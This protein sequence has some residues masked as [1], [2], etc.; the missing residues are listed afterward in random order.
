MD[1][2]RFHV[3]GLVTDEA[4]REVSG[5]EVTVFLQR[6]RD[7][8]PLAR[9]RADEDGRY[10]LSYEPPEHV[11]GRVMLVV[12]ATG[13]GLQGDIESPI[14]EAAPDLEVNLTRTPREMSEFSV[15]EREVLPLLDGLSLD[16]VVESAEHQDIS[17]LAVD[18]NRGTEAITRLVLAARL[19]S[20]YVIPAVVFYAF[21]ALRV[22]SAI[23]SPL[24]P[25]T[26]NWELI[27]G[28]VKRIASLIFVLTPDVQKQTLQRASDGGT[29]PAT[30]PGHID[31]FVAQLQARRVADALDGPFQV[32]KATLGELLTVAKLP[33]QKQQAFATALTNN[34]ESMRNFWRHLS[35]PGSGFTPAEASSIQRSLEVGSFTKNH[36][37]LVTALVDRFASGQYTSMADL[38]RLPL[39][40]WNDLVAQV[41]P[42]ANV[43]AAG[44]L[45]AAQVYAKVIYTRVTRAFPTV[46]LSTRLSDS[47]V[48]P[49]N[50][51]DSL[52][53]FFTNNPKLE[54]VKANVTTYVEQ[55]GEEAFSGIAVE[56]RPAVIE[57]AKQLQRVLRVTPNVD[58]AEALLRSGI[59]SA[60][61]I[62]TLGRQQFFAK[63]VEL[64]LTKREANRVYNMGAQ[65]YADTVSL[66]TQ[67]NRSL[68]GD[69]PRAV[70]STSDLDE[71]TAQAVKR[72]QSLATLFGSQDYC[73]TDN[74]TSILSA[75]AYLC[76]LL[77]WLRNHPLSGPYANALLALRARRPD[78]EHLLLN[79]PNTE[80]PLPYIDLVNELLEDAVA[81]PAMPV[82]RQTTLTPP[83]LRAAPEYVN[84]DAYIA[85][86]AANYPHTLPYDKAMDELRTYLGQS[87][88]E[89]W[90]LRRQLLPLHSPTLPQRAGVAAARFGIDAH[91]TDLICTPNDVTAAVAWNTANPGVDLVGVPAFLQAA[92]I[93]YE[94][95]LE[96]L[97]VVWIRAGGAPLT[98]Q[99]VDDTCDL[100]LQSLAPAPLDAGD[101]D[102][103]HR[104][105]RMWRH[106]NWTMWE[107]DLL[108]SA[109]AVGAGVLDENAL[110]QLAAFN[111]LQHA[112]RLGVDELL[113]LFGNIDLLSHRDPS[114]DLTTSL[115]ARLFLDPSVPADP[116]LA[117]LSIGA[118][119]ADPV[120]SHHV[121]SVR[122]ALQV[123]ADDATTLMTLTDGTLTLA[124]L[125]KMCR[126]AALATVVQLTIDD[127]LRVI[128]VAGLGDTDAALTAIVH[129]AGTTLDFIQNVRDVKQSGFSIDEVMYVLTKQPT[130]VG[131]TTD[132]ITAAV[133]PAVRTAMQAA[134]DE[135][136]TSADPALTVLQRELAQLPQFADSATLA[137]MISIVDDTYS[138]ALAARN[139]FI[140]ANLVQFMD[141]ATAQ[142]DL[143]PLPGGLTHA[144]RQAAVTQRAQQ[145]LNPLAVYLT[146]TRVTAALAAATQLQPAVV[147][148]LMRQVD[149]PGTTTTML[150]TLTDPAIIHKTGGVYTPITSANFPN[151]FAAIQL[152][153]KIGT[154]VRRLH[155]VPTDLGWLLTNAATYGGPDLRQLPVLPAT[156]ELSYPAL[157]ATS[158][159]VKLDRSFS[160]APSGAAY[161]DLYSVIAAVSSGG[162]ASAGATQTALGVI[163]GWDATDIGLLATTLGV[164]FPSDYTNPKTYDALRRLDAMMAASGGNATQL[165]SWGV[166][167]PSPTAAADSV[168]S[169]LKSRY[170][171]AD[172][173]QL[174]P[175]LMDPLRERRSAALQA[176][177]LAKRDGGGALLFS[178][179][180]ALFEHFLIDVEMSSCQVTTRVIQAYA[181]VQLFVERAL[182]ALEE[183]NVVVDP[184][185][186]DTW[187]QWQ[188]MKRYRVW[189]AAREVFLYPENWLVESQRP[190]RTEL[191][192]KLEQEVHQNENTADYLETVAL[193]YIDRL[194][195][196]AHLTVTGTC[197][198]PHTGAVHVVARTVADP[199]KFYHR[200]FADRTWSG[201]QQIPVDIK[202]HQAVP[203]VFRRRLCIFWAEVKV[204]G[205]PRQDVP[206]A[207]ASTNAPPDPA[208]YVS[209]GLNF[210]VFRNGAW[211]PQ[212]RSRGRLFDLP[213]LN[214]QTVSNSTAIEALYTLKVQTPAPAPG[215]GAS[216]SIDVFRLG[217]YDVDEFSFFVFDVFFP[218][219]DRPNAAVHIGRATF[220]G[221]F[222]DLEQRNLDIVIG[223][224]K[225][226][227]LEHA[228]TAYGPDALPLLELPSAQ[229][230]PNLAPEPGPLIPQGG[231][232]TTAPPH[233]SGT[234]PLVFTSASSLQQGNGPLLNTGQVPFRVIGDDSDIEFDPGS[235]F[236]YQDNRR[237]YFVES[238]K[239]YQWGSAWLPNPPSYASTAPYEQRYAFH[240]FY[241][242]Y[243]RLMW[244]QLSGGGFPALY[245]R[246]FQL[247]PDTVDPSGADRFSFRNTYNPVTPRVSWGE[248]NEIIAFEPDA[249]YSVYNWELFFHTPLY[250]AERLSQN[251]RFEDALAWFHYLFDPTRSGTEPVPQRFWITKPLNTLTTTA[252]LQERINN[253][254][255]AV[256]H[257]DANAVAQVARWRRD[258]FNPFLLADQRPVAYM[259]RVVMSYLDNLIAW[260]DNLFSSD[261]REALNEATLLYVIAAEI[262]GPRPVAVTP[263]QHLDA[264][265]HDL[266]PKLDA[267]ANAMVA[268]ENVVPMGGGG[269]GGGGNIPVPQTFYFKIP[270]NDTLL[271]YWTTVA[272]RLLKLRHCQN[273]QG[274]T[275]VLALF[276]ASI[277]PG[278][279]VRAQAAG[280]DLGSVLNDL[281]APR[282]GY[283]FATLYTQALDFS[284]AVQQYGAKLLAALERSDAEA[285]SMLLTVQ[286]QQMAAELDQVFQSRVDETQKQIEALEQSIALA[287]AKYDDAHDHP[288]VNAAEGVY[289]GVKGSV[290][291]A[292]IVSGVIH[293]IAG[294]LALLPDFGLG[295]A[296][297]GGSPSAD[298]TEGGQNANEAAKGAAEQGKALADSLSNAADLSKTIGEFMERADDNAE[299]AKEADIEKK[300]AE[301]R[302]AAAQIRLAIAQAEQVNHQ[303]EESRIQ[304][305]LDWLTHKLTSQDLY[306]WMIGQLSDTYFQAY[307]LAYKMGKQAEQCYRYEL[308]LI[309][310]SFVQFGYWDS[311]KKGLLAGESLAHDLR[312]MEAS[313][314]EQNSR[315]FEITR[316]VSLAELKPQQLLKLLETGTCDVDLTE[317]LF[318]GDYPGHYQRRLQRVSVTVEYPHA[319]VNDNIKCTLTLTKN[320]VRMTT[321]LSAGYQRQA[322]TDPRF[323]D[324][325]G[326]VP[327]KVALSSGQKDPGLFLT[328]MSDNLADARYLPFEGAGA[329]STW[330][331]EMPSVSNDVDLGTVTDVVLHLSYTALD[332]GDSFKQAA[333]A[334]LA[335]NMPTS[336]SLLLSASADFEPDT[337]SR[338]LSGPGGGGDQVLTLAVAPSQF[339]RWARGKTITVTGLTVLAT[340]THS[341]SFVAQPQAPL[342]AAPVTLNPVAGVTQPNVTS[343]PVAIVNGSPGTWTFKIRTS[344]AANF[345]S[346]TPDDIDDVLLL[347]AFQVS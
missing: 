294:G 49:P 12:T 264:S 88:I 7:R 224:S 322:G 51:R 4:G 202:A 159:L 222:S 303:N 331:I 19:E 269:G 48:V 323:V 103:I 61:E 142:A 27:D 212:Q 73:A 211:S 28:L 337:W 100:S 347:I 240:R 74:C 236:I 94:H 120:L 215:Y 288:F 59:G 26:Q 185:R 339:P 177:L 203:A 201:W 219:L 245:D 102:R 97:D 144:Q 239:Y 207:Q 182:M 256:D 21:L 341:G 249:A 194:D 110:V 116:D 205:E 156:V 164:L 220:D 64:G 259:K 1:E 54:L 344:G 90:Q 270:P 112:T 184:N 226:H 334:D 139:A 324:E 190:N 68:I 218:V 284:A 72:D 17:F 265:Y 313:Y 204:V 11:P 246:N 253:L 227:M 175:T 268:I 24:L 82:W 20:A 180:N 276:D 293:A 342:P 228:Q 213:I 296:G 98:L 316:N 216:L 30:S 36:L 117:A 237:G 232:L 80:V 214:S 286:R 62:A 338:F 274:V 3:H 16:D 200:T 329:I 173:L 119:V 2:T 121:A 287:Q 32:G 113:A 312:R 122:A 132:Q 193:N 33:A 217:D 96:L 345:H 87:G 78:V 41:G 333:A 319:E 101:L 330:R 37:P 45:S 188:W 40:E 136:F 315:R 143:G 56:Q 257:G 22:P 158:L 244:H 278:L 221:R 163:S 75:A 242:P 169:V 291:L 168:L 85:L 307:R 25:A 105:L 108:L 230:E 196:I 10:R 285:L 9:S 31:E 251:Q 131:L 145:V 126:F 42:P 170:G 83:Q 282:P 198:D 92:D 47:E 34:T 160:S 111:E 162:L 195:E 305:R 5:A 50:E 106:A 243:T 29:I 290:I 133:L 189:Q 300:R 65:R 248:D 14:V 15:L 63:A 326:T 148:L 187:S 306:D 152:L 340:S 255:L 325:F 191:F 241:H 167:A 304:T 271:G 225:Q 317:Q 39:S 273:I 76:D 174:A 60:A 134:H 314:L 172:W 332:G 135:I 186:D 292:N 298:A 277:D 343:G 44:E 261:S 295:V 210:T 124:N 104:F 192:Q 81:P 58:T 147:S 114:G 263:P 99:G 229:S 231:A 151:Q 79:C 155:L 197:T 118:A 209:I 267:F 125:S 281:S 279:L 280:V 289:L 109:P 302:L 130:S 154:V 235:H 250:I 309:D 55:T 199:P 67:L 69:W 38:A 23:P 321:D 66:F 299:K 165:V 89:L 128:S 283:R 123:S 181:A 153:D 346:L 234:M 43:N 275:R 157:L 320:S 52:V 178:D 86:A 238:V 13:E 183:P 161:A 46:A 93:T 179:T 208:K 115:Y 8:R 258:P 310:S 129:D 335:A 297:F 18:T 318:D 70:G 141:V 336:G 149:T 138:G 254:L 223:I 272:D 308:G 91:E 252:I 127:L 327:Q 176:F 95:L 57:R 171:E 6:I 247:S 166:V 206:P 77:L 35:G 260:A 262:L 301:A 233:T 140:A 53:R 311:L 266:E 71:P 146:Q 328:A 137:T 107:L 150:T 84:P